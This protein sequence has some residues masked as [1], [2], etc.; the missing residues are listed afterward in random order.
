[1]HT[2]WH[3]YASP[4]SA[5]TFEFDIM[6]LCNEASIANAVKH[7]CKLWNIQKGEP[8]T[9]LPLHVHFLWWHIFCV[10]VILL[11]G[12]IWKNITIQKTVQAAATV[13]EGH[14]LVSAKQLR[15]HWLKHLRLHQSLAESS[16]FQSR[17]FTCA[18]H[19][20]LH[21]ITE[22]CIHS[23]R[24]CETS[25]MNTEMSPT[26]THLHLS[27]QGLDDIVPKLGGT[28]GPRKT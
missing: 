17:H 8:G 5:V 18:K 12:R 21:Q 4:M 23:I 10:T 2:I 15:A 24:A 6:L 19:H 22:D 9:L 25:G 11:H 3:I 20:I 7:H 26:V 13:L 28:K 16:G 27:L 1:M 14:F